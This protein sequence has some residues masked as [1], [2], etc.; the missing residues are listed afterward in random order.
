MD[1]QRDFYRPTPCLSVE[2]TR[3]ILEEMER[4]C[5]DAWLVNYTNP[6]NLVSE[7]ISHHS[8]IR[9]VSLCE[10][11]LTFPADLARTAG[12]DPAVE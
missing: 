6:V 10:G 5:P 1:E 9:C 4:R 8:P 7:A 2:G 3:E 12:L 11:P